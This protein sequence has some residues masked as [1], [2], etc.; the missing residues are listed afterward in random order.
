MFGIFKSKPQ[1]PL[2][3]YF[4]L[5]TDI[6]SHI[7][8]G[9]DDGSP[10][11]ATSLSLV[12]GL[13]KLGVKSSVATPHIIGDIY[14]NDRATITAALE[15]LRAALAENNIDF[16]VNAA[17]EYML[18]AYFLELLHD[19]VPLLTL[20]D[21]LVLTEFSYLEKPYNAEQMVFSLI[22]EGYRP[23]LAHPERYS[24]FHNDHK[25]YDHLKDLGFLL[26]VNLLSLTGYYGKPAA[27][28]AAYILKNGLASF[29]GTDLHHERHMQALHHPPN[30][31]LFRG[32]F[33]GKMVNEEMAF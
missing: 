26:Q 4:P 33:G 17:A 27:K 13:M 31:E 28:A 14:R 15:K 21:N 7:L 12:E 24:Y 30:L 3:G 11:I 20:K 9:V 29:T 8:P 18:D 16:K 1:Q 32:A 22:T 6:H 19:K 2:N 10:D 23:V 25:Q 5:Y